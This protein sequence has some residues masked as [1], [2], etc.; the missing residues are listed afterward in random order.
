MGEFDS[1][2]CE[3]RHTDLDRRVAVVETTIKDNLI[4]I[5]DKLDS[6]GKRPTWA[7][8]VVLTLLTS[9]CTGMAMFLI[10]KGH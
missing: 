2:L 4:R 7:V 3:V 1:Q 6:M 9:A 10:T 8:A 5:Y